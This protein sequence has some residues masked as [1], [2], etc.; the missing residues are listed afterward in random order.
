MLQSHTYYFEVILS[1]RKKGSWRDFKKAIEEYFYLHRCIIVYLTPYPY[2][3]VFFCCAY[4]P[5]K[6][7][8]YVLVWL[9]NGLGGVI[10]P[11]AA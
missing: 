8:P 6:M 4:L 5:S 3:D 1:T 11:Q 9:K 2:V 7:D 10:S